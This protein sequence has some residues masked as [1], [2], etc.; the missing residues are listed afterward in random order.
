MKNIYKNYYAHR[1]GTDASCLSYDIYS[2]ESALVQGVVCPEP[3]EE[4]HLIF[5]V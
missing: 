4:N 3:E 1:N 2:I 5:L